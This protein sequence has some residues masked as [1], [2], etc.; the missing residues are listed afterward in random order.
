MQNSKTNYIVKVAMLSAAATILFFIKAPIPFIAPPFYE[1][2]LSNIASLIGSFAL[3]PM[4]GVLIELIKNLLN[5]M[6]DGSITGGVGELSN[7]LTG[8]AFVL[9]SSI[10][11]MKNKNKNSAII[12]LLAGVIVMTAFSYISNIYIMIPAYS[13]ALSLPIENI[14]SMGT[15]IHESID[16]MNDMVLLCAVPFNMIKGVI[17]SILTFLLYKK[18]RTIL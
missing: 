6:I 16:S 8:C 11:F 9:P 3:G 17:L 10:L 5:L 7:F 1:F 2:D 14:V 15:A 18:I 4:A 12:G 13:K